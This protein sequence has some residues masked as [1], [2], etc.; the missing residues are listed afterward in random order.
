VRTKIRNSKRGGITVFL[1]IILSAVILT[2]SVLFCAA[3]ERGVEAELKKCMQLQTAQILCNYNELLLSNYGLYALEDNA[4]N[5]D[6][7][8]TCFQESSETTVAVNTEYDMTKLQ[9]QTGIID[10]MKL[11]IPAIAGNEIL[12]RLKGVLSQIN[13]NEI[14][15]QSKNA[16]TSAWLG[17]FKD[18]LSGKDSWSNI[19]SNVAS[20]LGVIDFTGKLSDLEAFASKYQTLTEQKSTQYLQGEADT[21]FA[22]SILQPQTLSD[23]MTYADSLLDY[24]YPDFSD[25]LMINQY[26]ISFFDSKLAHVADGDTEIAEK[27]ILGTPYS[28]IHKGN[29]ADLEYVLSGIE[30]ETVSSASVAILI[31]DIRTIL[32]FGSFLLDKT[33]VEEA[34]GIADVVSA[35]ITI[36]S[37]GSITID[38]AV[39]TYAVL[40]VMALI[41][42]IKDIRQLQNGESITLFM[43]P[44]ITNQPGLEE[45]LMT[46]YRDYIGFF[47]LFVPIEWKTSRILTVLKRDC[48]KHLYTGVRITVNYRN[49]VFELEDSYDAYA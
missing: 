5:Q 14:V 12:S 41:Q 40:F 45:L 1:C 10:F 17:T 31:M 46:D 16:D 48:G 21:D 4:V 27:N 42:G 38:P 28:E 47:L 3:R 29:H 24:D 18:Y 36:I 49:N 2:E 26:A 11:R 6:I 44:T 37:A 13:G 43:H 30:D 33:K 8:S 35:A 39:V 15:T 20:F 25:A 7:F 34:R 32:N 22:Y 19:L 9:V 23:M